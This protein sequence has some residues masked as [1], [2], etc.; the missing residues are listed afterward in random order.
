MA[1]TD[2]SKRC[3]CDAGHATF[4]ACIRAKSLLVQPAG[5]HGAVQA[6]D[7]RLSDFAACVKNGVT[8]KTT[9]RADVDAAVRVLR[10]QK[11]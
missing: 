8:P 10:N 7:S 3:G 6:W 1:L 2:G 5:Q 11:D 4:G 9:K